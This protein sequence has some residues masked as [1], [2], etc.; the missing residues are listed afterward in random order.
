MRVLNRT[1]SGVL[2]ISPQGR[3]T[4]LILAAGLTFI[5]NIP[6]LARNHDGQVTTAAAKVKACVRDR[7]GK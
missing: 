7:A 4:P 3:L 1:I 5:G 2:A 6:N